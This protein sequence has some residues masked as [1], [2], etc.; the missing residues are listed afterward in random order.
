MEE[1]QTLSP[2]FPD[3]KDFYFVEVYKPEVVY[4][5][6]VTVNSE[7]ISHAVNILKEEQLPLDE[8][9]KIILYR[10]Y[11]FIL[12]DTGEVFMA[13][14]T[15]NFQAFFREHSSERP[16]LIEITETPPIDFETLFPQFP[17]SF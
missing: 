14:T 16:D 12:R 13:A 4:T 10:N 5:D 15:M 7:P 11:P 6:P 17:K 2:A 1:T 3:K 9:V 8:I